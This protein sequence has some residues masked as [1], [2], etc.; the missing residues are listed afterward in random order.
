MEFKY[1]VNG[2]E[3]R[4]LTADD[5][6]YNPECYK[7]DR[8][9][10]LERLINWCIF[11]PEDDT[12]PHYFMRNMEPDRYRWGGII[13]C[14]DGPLSQ[15]TSAHHTDI[16]QDDCPTTTYGIVSDNP[17]T[18]EIKSEKPFTE[19]RYTEN[20]ATWKESDVF[21][22]KAEFFPFAIF[23][24][25]DSIYPTTYW[26]QHVILTGTYQ[27]KPI[28]TMGCFDRVFIPENT[29]MEEFMKKALIY[30]SGY[31][32]GIRKDGRKECVWTMISEQNGKGV[33]VYWLEGEE[34]VITSE[35]HLEADWQH[36]PFAPDDPSVSYTKATWTFGGKVI[37]FD[38]KWSGKG[39]TPTPRMWTPGLTQCYGTWY[40]GDTPYE[41]EVWHTFGENDFITADQAR[42]MGFKVKE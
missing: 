40:E 9:A 25:L 31:F 35:V 38:V 22:L 3:V 15:Q 24:H 2:I 11:F 13:R 41:H 27:G 33:G 20:S 23:T 18:Y 37:H 28:K 30:V 42:S 7:R 14:G 19:Y 17:I 36:L 6:G 29:D 12:N 8:N 16:A 34:P 32:S 21:D 1:N 10:K 4:K 39:H 5:L 26:V